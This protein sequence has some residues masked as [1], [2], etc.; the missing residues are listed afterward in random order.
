ME[1]SLIRSGQ[2]MVG[3]LVRPLRFG[4]TSRATNPGPV[5]CDF[6]TSFTCF[7]CNPAALKAEPLAP[8]SPLFAWSKQASAGHQ[9]S[10]GGRGWNLGCAAG[11]T[12]SLKVQAQ[13]GKTQALL[14][15]AWPDSW[16]LGG[17]P[18]A[19]QISSAR[20]VG[21]QQTSQRRAPVAWIGGPFLRRQALTPRSPHHWGCASST[22]ASGQRGGKGRGA[23]RQ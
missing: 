9:G 20:S 23:V 6:T 8:P 11:C 21:K 3:F 4:P 22:P 7:H 10:L 5:W 19:G 1:M 13:A 14:R 12:R 2:E 15:E 17:S 18:L 16:R